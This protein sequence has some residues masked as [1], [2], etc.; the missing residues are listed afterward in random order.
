MPSLTSRRTLGEHGFCGTALRAATSASNFMVSA[1]QA[2]A[3]LTTDG[4]RING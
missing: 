2:S 4:Q 1:K 3:K